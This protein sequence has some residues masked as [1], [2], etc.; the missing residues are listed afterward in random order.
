MSGE[1]KEPSSINSA[2]PFLFL[3]DGGR[4]IVNFAIT[5][6]CN[7]KCKYCSFHKEKNKRC[8]TLED[9]RRAIDYLYEINTGVLALTGG[10]PFLNPF[11][12][13]IIRYARKKG[14][15]VYTGTNSIPLTEDLSKELRKAD[16]S[17]VWISFE[18]SSYNIFNQNRGVPKLHIKVKDGLKYLRDAGITV[19]AISLVN[20]SI[21]DF[22]LLVKCL[23][24]LGFDKVKFDYP[25][26]FKLESSYKGW[27]DSPLLNYS[28]SEM[29]IAIKAILKIKKNTQIKVINPIAGLMGAMDFYHHRPPKYPCYAGEKVLYL[30][31]N[32]DIYRCPAKG[33]KLGVVDD[34]ID[35]KKIKCNMCYYQ[36]VRDY[37]PFYYF[38]ERFETISKNL[39]KLNPNTLFS[40]LNAE[41]IKK[42]YDG[43][44]ASREIR[45]CGLV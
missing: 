11:L 29:D 7:A 25:I 14:L 45:E 30:D 4:K 37:D 43:F 3:R 19:F 24:E 28:A 40:S 10:E 26:N 12:P 9:A 34:D 13:D 8:V 41:E 32:L 6:F 31:W 44:Q 38:L 16:I 35:F 20:K 1:L 21:T 18:S 2:D 36:G 22:D 17:A 33:E 39:L 23:I 15:I 42:L 27:S 5:N